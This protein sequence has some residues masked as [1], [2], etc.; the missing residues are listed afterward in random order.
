MRHDTMHDH[1]YQGNLFGDVTD[2]SEP[3]SKSRAARPRFRAG[4]VTKAIWRE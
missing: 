3:Q 2:R 4:V 1:V